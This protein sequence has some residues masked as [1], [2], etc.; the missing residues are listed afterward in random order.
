MAI[1]LRCLNLLKHIDFRVSFR[2]IFKAFTGITA[3]DVYLLETVGI[4]AFGIAWLVK[5]EVMND[6]I[7]LKHYITPKK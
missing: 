7:Q 6:L 5:G 2:L 4:V 1:Q 3:F